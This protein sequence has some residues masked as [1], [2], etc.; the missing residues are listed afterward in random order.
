MHSDRVKE[1]SEGRIKGGFRLREG[2][3]DSCINFDC[4]NIL[5]VRIQRAL[6]NMF[7]QCPLPCFGWDSA[8]REDADG[9]RN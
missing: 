9:A 7:V 4:V 6:S 1:G 3:H 5:S 2:K 8:A